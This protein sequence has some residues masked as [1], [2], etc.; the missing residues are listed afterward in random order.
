MTAVVPGL[1]ADDV[2]SIARSGSG[3]MPPV[4]SDL[5]DAQTLGEWVVEEWGD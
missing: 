1:T 3:S 2:A 5:D 4:I